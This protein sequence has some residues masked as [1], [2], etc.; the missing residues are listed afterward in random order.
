MNHSVSQ[1]ATS[2]LDFDILILITMKLFIPKSTII[3]A[4]K[5]KELLNI[6]RDV[7]S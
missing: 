7:R 4:D 2:A 6:L 1:I 5:Q 3:L